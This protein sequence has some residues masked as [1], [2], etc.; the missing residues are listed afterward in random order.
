MTSPWLQNSS[1]QR[2]EPETGN[3]VDRILDK[4]VV[5]DP[6]SRPLPTQRPVWAT[7]DGLK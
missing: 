5:S 1:V 2:S 3:G 6:G 4:S 7:Q